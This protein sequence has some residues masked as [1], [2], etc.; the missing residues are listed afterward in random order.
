MYD[1]AE[2]LAQDD[3]LKS[4]ILPSPHRTCPT[5]DGDHGDDLRN[6]VRHLYRQKVAGSAIHEVMDLP[7]TDDGAC[8]Y[9]Q[10][11]DFEPDEYD[12]LVGHYAHANIPSVVENRTI[13]IDEF[14]EEA[15]VTP[16]DDPDTVVSAFLSRRRG[17][18]FDDWTDF[19]EHRYERRAEAVS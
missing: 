11:W 4:K 19:V 14:A 18:P 5:F 17:L 7:C 1:Q 8:P 15:L 16:F 9:Q 13:V 2:E 12:V 10:A 6:R 3:S